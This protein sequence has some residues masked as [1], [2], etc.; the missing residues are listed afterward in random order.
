MYEC[1][2]VATIYVGFGFLGFAV[3]GDIRFLKSV[4]TGRR[5][6]FLQKR[7]CFLGFAAAG[8]MHYFL[9]IVTGGHICF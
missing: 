1:P 6:C 2:L 4:E 9:S 8:D 3:A 5:I 7:L